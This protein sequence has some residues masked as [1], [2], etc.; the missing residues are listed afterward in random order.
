M[1]KLLFRIGFIGQM[2]EWLE[3][4]FFIADRDCHGLGGEDG[5]VPFAVDKVTVSFEEVRGKE[6]FRAEG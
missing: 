4:H 3:L 2:I 5:V 6:D 1:R